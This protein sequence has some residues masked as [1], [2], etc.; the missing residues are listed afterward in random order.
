[1]ARGCLNSYSLLS[2][3]SE[4]I[5]NERQAQEDLPPQFIQSTKP[6]RATLVLASFGPSKAFSNHVL[7]LDVSFN[8]DAGPPKYEKP[9]RFGKLPEIN[10]IFKPDPKS[11]PIVI[12]IFFVLAILASVPILLGTVIPQ[13][14][15]LTVETQLTK[16]SSGHTSVRT[17]TISR[18]LCRQLQFR[19]DCSS[20]QYCRWR[21]SFSFI[22]T[23]GHCSR[24][25]RSLVS[26]VSLP[27]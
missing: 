24:C 25:Y 3:G 1:M 10:H 19:M 16:S 23:T 20:V 4:E 9:L 15:Y 26:L 18:N 21:G 17:S 14:H 22:T 5:A 12:S 7:D 27:L 8:A 11:G 6:L 13:R 2:H